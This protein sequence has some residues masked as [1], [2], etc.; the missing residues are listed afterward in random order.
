MLGARFPRELRSLYLA[1]DGFRGP[2]EARFLW[3]LLA[4]DGIVDFNGFLREGSEFP[5][6]FVSSCL[7]FGDAGIG[8]MWGFKDDLPGQIIRWSTSWGDDF[9]IAGTSMLDVWM[10]EKKTYDELAR[11]G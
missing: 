9:E 4:K 8:D 1:F 2:T 11:K 3:P 6:S 7:F 5:R 10:G